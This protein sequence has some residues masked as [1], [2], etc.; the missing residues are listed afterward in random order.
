[1]PKMGA[2]APGLPDLRDT[3][4]HRLRLVRQRELTGRFQPRLRIVRLRPAVDIH[5]RRQSGV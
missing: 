4:C 3:P 5:V 2:R 1:M